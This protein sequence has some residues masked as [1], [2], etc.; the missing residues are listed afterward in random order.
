MASI[1]ST[2]DY[3]HATSIFPEKFLVNQQV[4]IRRLYFGGARR[5]APGTLAPRHPGTP[6]PRHAGIRHPASGTRRAGPFI[7]AEGRPGSDRHVLFWK[8]LVSGVKKRSQIRN[9]I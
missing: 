3:W 2:L 5:P 4:A 9:K 8:R 1:C 7:G 6:G